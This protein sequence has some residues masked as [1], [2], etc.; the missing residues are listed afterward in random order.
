MAP[1]R[2]I[3]VP[4]DFSR[5]SD[6]ALDAACELARRFEAPILLLHAYVIPTYPLPEGYVM[7]S[8]ET[9]AEV[10]SKTKEAMDRYKAKAVA[11]GIQKVD[12]LMTEGPAFAEIIRVARTENIDLIVMGTH[13][14]TG[15]KHALLG[16]VAEKVV[17]KSPCAVLTIRD[18]EHRFEKP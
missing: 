6:D 3:L 9:V 17:R 15:I 5:C 13:G 1:F 11:Q 10:L 4:L 2:K 16:S 18:A 8:A 12:V 7:A 14:R